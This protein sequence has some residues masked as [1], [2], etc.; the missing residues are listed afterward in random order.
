MSHQGVVLIVRAA[1]VAFMIFAV[2]AP[3]SPRGAVRIPYSVA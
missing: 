3:D 2:R 1:L